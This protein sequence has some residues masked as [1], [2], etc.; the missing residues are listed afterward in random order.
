MSVR[1]DELAAAT[2]TATAQ[3]DKKA[4]QAILDQASKELAVV[5]TPGVR[6]VSQH[7][8]RRVSDQGRR[9]CNGWLP[10]LRRHEFP[11]LTT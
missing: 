10:M 1:L 7:C 6:S 5:K 8:P 11:D 2:A 3:K 4:A 9:H